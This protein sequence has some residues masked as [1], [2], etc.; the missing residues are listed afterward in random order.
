VD[1]PDNDLP[2]LIRD[3][4]QTLNQFSFPELKR[5]RVPAGAPA[6]PELVAWAAKV[7]CFSWTRH[8]CTLLE[9]TVTV[10]ESGNNQSARVLARSIYELGAHAYY[11]KKHLKQHIQE[12]KFSAAWEFLTPIATGSRY[13]NEQIPE[14]S[15][16]FPA[17][18]HISKAIKCFSE[19]M[20]QSA[21]DDYSYLSEFC[22]PNVLAFFQYYEWFDPET[23]RFVDYKPIEG[24]L[25]ATTAAVI[26]GLLAAQ[27]L[28]AIVREQDVRRS[29]VALLRTIAEKASTTD[30]A[31]A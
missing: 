5:P 12:A 30:T 28:L 3:I 14:E 31:S 6:T 19:V 24:F 9:G 16:L 23:V 29:L 17:P 21:Q 27:E 18:A 13:M 22:H 2:A 1:K 11:V 10:L 25:G 15:E 8:L 7:Y 4:A 26:Q 20:P